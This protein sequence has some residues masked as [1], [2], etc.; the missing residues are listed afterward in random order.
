MNITINSEQNTLTSIEF[1]LN[2]NIVIPYN[3]AAANQR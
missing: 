1:F 2:T 3:A